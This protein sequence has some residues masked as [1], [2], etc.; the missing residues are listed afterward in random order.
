MRHERQRGIDPE[1]LSIEDLEHIHT[2]YGIDMEEHKPLKV[3]QNLSRRSTPLEEHMDL[4]SPLFED[5]GIDALVKKLK[6]ILKTGSQENGEYFRSPL[7]DSGLEK[8]RKLKMLE[9]NVL[10]TL[11]NSTR[12]QADAQPPNMTLLRKIADHLYLLLVKA[13]DLQAQ[14]ELSRN[15]ERFDTELSQEIKKI[16]NCKK[17]L[18]Q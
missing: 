8:K 9:F 4:M 7:G 15:F 2:T 1:L 3:I 6:A 14:V 18:S 5:S 13:Q 17:P 16:I 10:E 11:V 12:G